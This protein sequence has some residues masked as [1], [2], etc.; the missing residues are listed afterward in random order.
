[1]A[2][3]AHGAGGG[4]ALSS[5]EQTVLKTWKPHEGR[6][7]GLCAERSGGEA[8]GESEP[9]SYGVTRARLP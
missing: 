3:P 5:R 9:Q 1:M 2:L 6:K 8:A 4:L 7:M